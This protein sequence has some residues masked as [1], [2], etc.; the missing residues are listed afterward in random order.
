MIF[1]SELHKFKNISSAVNGLRIVVRDMFLVLLFIALQLQEKA[2][3]VQALHMKRS[4]LI[5]L[6][7]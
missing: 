5:C 7:D 1:L 2:T 4:V 3:D 6:L